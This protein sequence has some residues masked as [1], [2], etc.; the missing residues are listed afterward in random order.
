MKSR[1]RSR[2]RRRVFF[3]S[4]GGTGRLRRFVDE[5][6][7]II[8]QL[9]TGEKILVRDA[10]FP[11]LAERGTRLLHVLF[12]EKRIEAAAFADQCPSFTQSENEFKRCP[13]REKK[14]DAF[15]AKERPKKIRGSAGEK[16]ELSKIPSAHPTD[17]V[18]ALVVMAK[19]AEEVNSPGFYVVKLVC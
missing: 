14:K 17:G 7:T 16:E 5:A 19:R 13:K 4:V 8:F 1:R 15:S 18:G 10:L 9:F 2:R 3:F 11:V 6:R 12:I